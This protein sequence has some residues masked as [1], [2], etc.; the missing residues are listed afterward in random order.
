ML[1]KISN[2]FDR[3]PVISG[4]TFLIIYFGGMF[5]N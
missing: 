1:R 4:L 3:H 5:I 2:F